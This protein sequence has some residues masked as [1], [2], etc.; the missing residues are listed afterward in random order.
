MADFTTMLSN[1]C[2]VR[3]VWQQMFRAY[4][5][6]HDDKAPC[7]VPA[8]SNQCAV[9]MSVALERCGFSLSAFGHNGN[10]GNH[11]R[12]HRN[13]RACQLPVPH[14]VG[15]H[16]LAVYLEDIW[17]APTRYRGRTLD[18][19]PSALGGLRGIIYFN[20]CFTR[21]DQE[22]RRGDHIDLWDGREFWNIKLGISAGGGV[23]SNA[24]L[25]NLADQVWFFP[26]L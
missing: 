1:R 26:L 17:G 9:R 25:F 6:Y 10:H 14:L 12:V 7:K 11:R 8:I 18:D 3:P 24:P 21:E 5:D 4:N 23:A 20:N 19:A 13:R 22:T 2:M 16:E 15:A